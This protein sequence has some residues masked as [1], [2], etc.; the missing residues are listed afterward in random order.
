M[1]SN[2]QI[3]SATA[4][5]PAET[6]LC[7][8]QALPE[9]LVHK[10]FDIY[11]PIELAVIRVLVSDSRMSG[12]ISDRRENAAKRDVLRFTEVLCDDCRAFFAKR[13]IGSGFA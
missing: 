3:S 8:L 6:G 12:S 11:V 9:A 13:L 2:D 1:I 4:F 10:D 7:E 5:A